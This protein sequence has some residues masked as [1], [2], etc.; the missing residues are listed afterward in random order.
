MFVW[1]FA[2]AGF[3]FY[4]TAAGR[5]LI[6]HYELSPSPSKDHPGASKCMEFTSSLEASQS[7]VS[8][9]LHSPD[10]PHTL[11]LSLSLHNSTRDIF[12]NPTSD[13]WKIMY[14]PPC[15]SPTIRTGL[16]RGQGIGT[17]SGNWLW[18]LTLVTYPKSLELSG[19]EWAVNNFFVE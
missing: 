11:F 9:R 18:R 15:L 1:W 7:T 17:R 16:P 5:R 4:S 12:I 19:R 3:C 6:P 2:L 8:T 14:I 13:F 10:L